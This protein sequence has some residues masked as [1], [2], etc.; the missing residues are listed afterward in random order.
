MNPRFPESP[1][2]SAVQPGGV[3]EDAGEGRPSA[4]LTTQR[5]LDR[6]LQVQICRIILYYTY[7]IGF[8]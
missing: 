6:P 2:A 1:T 4:H 8:A 3:Y 5:R 7:I